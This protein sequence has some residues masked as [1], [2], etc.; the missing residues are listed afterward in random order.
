MSPPENAD[1][2]RRVSEASAKHGRSP[3]Y[4]LEPLQQALSDRGS[5]APLVLR[6]GGGESAP[7]K[8]HPPSNVA[9]DKARNFGT[10]GWPWFTPKVAEDK[11]RNF[12][13]A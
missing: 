13:T 12:G 7:I 3:N 6:G 4:P 5:P 2:L 9:L 11:A 1:C 10:A 8:A